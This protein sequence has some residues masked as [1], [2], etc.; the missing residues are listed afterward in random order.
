MV[1]RSNY[2]H[3]T[4]KYVSYMLFYLQAW[5][6]SHGDDPSDREW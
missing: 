1:F 3:V 5:K 6:C 2:R 4:L